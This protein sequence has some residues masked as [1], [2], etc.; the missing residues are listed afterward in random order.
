MLLTEKQ[1]TLLVT[2]KQNHLITQSH[3]LLIAQQ[4]GSRMF[5]PIMCKIGE[6]KWAK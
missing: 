5:V 2:H 1:M 6:A 3:P 4:T